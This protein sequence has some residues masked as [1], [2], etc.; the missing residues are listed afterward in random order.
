MSKETTD[1]RYAARDAE[2][3]W[4][5]HKQNCPWCMFPQ[6]QRNPCAAGKPLRDGMRDAQAE[7]RH[8]RELDKAP[9]AGQQS[10]FE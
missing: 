5:E 8:Q 9:M 2:R 7:A 1:A 4:K 10:L 6:G 3:A